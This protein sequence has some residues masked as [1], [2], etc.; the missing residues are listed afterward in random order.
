[1][2]WSSA[3]F[4]FLIL[5]CI[6]YLYWFQTFGKSYPQ[7]TQVNKELTHIRRMDLSTLIS[8]KNPFPIVGVLGGTFHF[9]SNFDETFCKR[10]VKI[11]IRHIILW[12]FIRICTVCLCPLKRALGVYRFK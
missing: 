9:C 11:L 3:D 4:L 1:M 5:Q 8:K 6:L 7:C 12:C 2:L 10:A